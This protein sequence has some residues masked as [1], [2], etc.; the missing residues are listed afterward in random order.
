MGSLGDDRKA[1]D[2][3]P[4][5][6]RGSTSAPPERSRPT[7][8]ARFTT[9][10]LYDTGKVQTLNPYSYSVKNPTT[11]ADPSGL[12]SM[13][14]WGGEP[15]LRDQNKELIAHIGRLGNHIEHIQAVI[16]KQ[17]KQVNQS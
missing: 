3:T 6:W 14:A 10:A 13:Y 11:F 2:V 17:K 16:R 5:P 8:A 12:Y 4:L 15:R 9:D 1:D 7:P